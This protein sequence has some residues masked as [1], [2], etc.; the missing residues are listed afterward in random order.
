M[1]TS[2]TLRLVVVAPDL[3]VSVAGNELAPAQSR[4]SRQLRTGPLENNC[5]LIAMLPA[6]IF[7]AG[8]LAQIQSDMIIGDAESEARDSLEQEVMA[9]RGARRPIVLFSN[10]NDTRQINDAVAAG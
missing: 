6:D 5:N 1:T 4:H 7:L 8:R 9:T 10:D 2:Q 3:T